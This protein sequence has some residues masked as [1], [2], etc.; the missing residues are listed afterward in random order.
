[1]R[2]S[3][4]HTSPKPTPVH[5]LPARSTD[6]SKRKRI[7]DYPIIQ[8]TPIT[9][10]RQRRAPTQQQQQ[11]PIEI[12]DI[13]EEVQQPRHHYTAEGIDVHR[14]YDPVSTNPPYQKIQHIPSRL[15]E[16]LAP[17]PISRLKTTPEDHGIPKGPI[18][19][20]LYAG[21]DDSTSLEAAI[22]NIAPW[23]APIVY[24]IGT[25][26][27]KT[28]HDMLADVYSHLYWKALRGEILAIIGG[29]NCRTWSVK[30]TWPDRNGNPGRPMRGRTEQDTWG[31]PHLTAAE[32]AKTD[33]DSVLLLRMLALYEAAS[34]TVPD[35][36][37]LLE[38]P[39]DPNYYS[40]PYEPQECPSIWATKTLQDFR[41]RHNMTTSTFSQCQLG[42]ETSK[43]TTLLL[44]DMPRLKRLNG[45][46]CTHRHWRNPDIQTSDPSRWAWGLNKAIAQSVNE[47]M[48]WLQEYLRTGK[49]PDRAGDTVRQ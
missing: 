22:Q 2:D 35:C 14:D 19:L 10:T 11:E 49:P 15:Q 8:D 29:P 27:D 7:T 37:F 24:A 43:P 3:T 26:R 25:L 30:L 34:S 41:T 5:F 31:L 38:H 17:T 28:R 36:K 48:P 16:R 32:Q 20:L 21:K 4:P 42:M 23:M 40:S 6:N 13:D 18:V 47:S 33:D 9:I 12:S 44:K 1:M 45:W 46:M 39:A